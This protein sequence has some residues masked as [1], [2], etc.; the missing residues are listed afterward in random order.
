MEA[1]LTDWGTEIILSL[2]ITMLG[3]FLKQSAKDKREQEKHYEALLQGEEERA[4]EEQIEVHLDPIYKELEDV[5]VRLLDIAD[6]ENA[7]LAR[8]NE[9]F[10]LILASY[11]YRLV[12]LCKQLLKQ[13]FMYQEQYENLNEF[14]TLYHSMGGNGQAKSYYEKCSKLD[15]KT[16]PDK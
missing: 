1:F 16:D 2:I 12:Q 9:N 13:G 8:I 5:R 4:V 11:K 15:I 10:D 14:Y 3:Y 7:D 6:K